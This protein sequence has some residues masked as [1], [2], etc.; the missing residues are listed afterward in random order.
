MLD[1]VFY[2]AFLHACHGHLRLIYRTT[3]EPANTYGGGILFSPHSLFPLSIPWKSLLLLPFTIFFFPIY[4]PNLPLSAPPSSFFPPP[5]P[6]AASTQKKIRPSKRAGHSC[7]GVSDFPSELSPSPHYFHFPW[8]PHRCIFFYFLLS[9]PPTHQPTPPSSAILYITF[10]AFFST[11]WTKS[12]LNLIACFITLR[13]RLSW[14]V[15]NWPKVTQQDSV[16]EYEFEL[17]SLSLKLWPLFYT[18]FCGAACCWTVQAAKP[19][20]DEQ[21]VASQLVAPPGSGGP[22]GSPLKRSCP[23]PLPWLLTETKASVINAVEIT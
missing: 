20:W 17:R 16:A 18:S 22:T 4:Q 15:Y 14:N 11:M 2:T 19:G 8:N 10:I 3:W 13:D 6:L 12:N 21:V 9:F 7:S 1:T 5:H 23:L